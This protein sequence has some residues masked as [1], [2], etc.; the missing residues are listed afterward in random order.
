M[1]GVTAPRAH[2][3][4]QQHHQPQ[5]TAPTAEDQA[6]TAAVM[7]RITASAIGAAA[8]W[9]AMVASLPGPP[10]QVAAGVGVPGDLAP[11]A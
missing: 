3:H 1:C 10:G 7:R 2:T 8:L 11:G 6:A 5:G 4:G 9:R